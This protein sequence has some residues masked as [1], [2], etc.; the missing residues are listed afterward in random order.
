MKTTTRR[1]VATFPATYQRLRS[2]EWGL[3]VQSESAQGG[4]IAV[5]TRKNGAATRKLIG[6]VVWQGQGVSLCTISDAPAP[7]ARSFDE[8]DYDGEDYPM[9]GVET[10]CSDRDYWDAHGD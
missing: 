9:H 3:R 6:K 8:E 2:G 5:A 7:P 10:F 4:D 1:A